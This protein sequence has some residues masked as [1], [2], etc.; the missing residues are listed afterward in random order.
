MLLRNLSLFERRDYTRLEKN[1]LRKLPRRPEVWQLL[2]GTSKFWSRIKA[3]TQRVVLYSGYNGK[4]LTNSYLDFRT[5]NAGNDTETNK[6][7]E[8]KL[9]GS[10]RPSF[11][12]RP[13]RLDLK[14]HQTMIQRDQGEVMIDHQNTGLSLG[15]WYSIRV[16]TSSSHVL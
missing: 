11:Q 9:Q 8:T 15:S 4:L 3:G 7:K 10:P 2:F 14:E 5:H 13:D 16:V 1:G 6:T 12:Q